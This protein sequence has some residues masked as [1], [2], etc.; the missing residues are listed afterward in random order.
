M[1]LEQDIIRVLTQAKDEIQANMASKR[2]N[3]SGRTSRGFRVEVYNGGIRLVLAHDE[4]A[5][6]TCA[7]RPPQGLSS[8]QVGTAPLSTLEVGMDGIKGRPPRG[9][10]YMIKQW[11]RD[12]GLTFASES[13]RQT[14]SYLTARKII[15]EGTRRNTHHED[16]YSTPLQ[17]AQAELQKDIRTYITGA[18][19]EAAQKNI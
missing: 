2:I 10:Y 17:K 19:Y 5:T 18:V 6:I 16:V 12:K 14:F 15:K 11:T 3:A 13:E 1:T 8:V 7:P 4:T 9:F